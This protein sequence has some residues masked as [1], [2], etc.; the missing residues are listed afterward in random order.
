[1]ATAASMAVPLQPATPTV[2]RTDGRRLRSERTRQ[3]IIE[4]YLALAEERSPHAPTAAEIAGRAGCSVRSIFERFSDILALQV[5]ATDH[6][7]NEI[8]ALAQTHGRDGDRLTRITAQVGMRARTC[9]RWLRLWRSLIVN[10]GQSD[11]LKQ[12]VLQS[13]QRAVA[14][15]DMML[16]PELSTLDDREHRQLLIVLEAL[17]DVESWGRMREFFGLSFDEACE[18]WVQ[19]IDR[20]LPSSRPIL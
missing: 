6:A 12:R 15:L 10:Q 5:A 16:V 11:E 1:M 7:M 14:R 4:A 8:V 17:T 13:R 18:L 19:A 2:A 3:A 9:E 20:L